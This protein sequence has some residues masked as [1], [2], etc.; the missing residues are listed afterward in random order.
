METTQR[1]SNHGTILRR[2]RSG[3]FEC[4]EKYLMRN[5]A[6]YRRTGS[7]KQRKNPRTAYTKEKFSTFSK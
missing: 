3:H 7:R 5:K 4:R 2:G 1:D 6:P